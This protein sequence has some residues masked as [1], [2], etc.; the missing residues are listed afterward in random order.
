MFSLVDTD[1]EDEN[2]IDALQQD[3][4]PSELSTFGDECVASLVRSGQFAVLT[5]HE[6]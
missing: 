2:V 5:K 4:E 6:Q 3:L 1:D